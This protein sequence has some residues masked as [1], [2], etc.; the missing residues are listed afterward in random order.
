Q[1]H[2]AKV[3]TPQPAVGKINPLTV[4]KPPRQGEGIGYRHPGPV[5]PDAPLAEDAV[6][7]PGQSIAAHSPLVNHTYNDAFRTGRDPT[8]VSF[9]HSTARRRM[10]T[11]RTAQINAGTGP[12]RNIRPHQ[13]IS[14]TP[15]SPGRKPRESPSATRKATAIDRM[16][17]S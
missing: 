12:A 4:D 13:H 15:R 17:T 8:R 14:M 3:G 7:E 2:P 6:L 10:R 5:K 11:R 16:Q 1:P 9:L